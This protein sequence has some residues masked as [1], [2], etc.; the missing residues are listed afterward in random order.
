MPKAKSTPLPKPLLKSYMKEEAGK[1][2]KPV[3]RMPN[4]DKKK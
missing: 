4:G 1:T 3:K 2:K